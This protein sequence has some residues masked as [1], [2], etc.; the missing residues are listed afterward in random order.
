MRLLLIFILLPFIST[1][2]QKNANAM[3]VRG[4]TYSQVMTLLLDNNYT[5]EKSDKEFG[6]I[7]TDWKKMCEN[8]APELQFNIRIKDSTAIIKGQWRT[9]DVFSGDILLFDIKNERSKVPQMAFSL[10]NN[11][12]TALGEVVYLVQ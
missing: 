12:A 2:Q 1:A 4:V 8:C 7:K 3:Q 10:M 9:K 5:V 6:T 11:I